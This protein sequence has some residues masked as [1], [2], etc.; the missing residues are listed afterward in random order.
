MVSDLPQFSRCRSRS[1]EDLSRPFVSSDRSMSA[2]RA[3]HPITTFPPLGERFLACDRLPLRSR[4]SL[5]SRKTRRVPLAARW[6]PPARGEIQSSGSSA[7]PAQ[8]R[9]TFRPLPD[10]ASGRRR[11]ILRPFHGRARG[12][13]LLTRSPS[14]FSPFPVSDGDPAVEVREV[15]CRSVCGSNRSARSA[16]RPC[17]EICVQHRSLLSLCP[18]SRRAT[19]RLWF[20]SSVRG[21]GGRTTSSSRS[22][23]PAGRGPRRET[24]HRLLCRCDGGDLMGLGP[25]AEVAGEVECLRDAATWATRAFAARD[26][27]P[28]T[29]PKA[30]ARVTTEVGPANAE[31]SSGRT[32]TPLPPRGSSG[33]IT[34]ERGAACPS[35][36]CRKTRHSR[37]SFL[38]CAVFFGRRPFR[39]ASRSSDQERERGSYDR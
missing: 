19:G 26:A 8:F 5:S 20:P 18:S 33:Q 15:R 13:L 30:R 23:A 16:L 37:A 29:A 28:S 17:L 7:E 3:I 10:G 27:A 14:C 9:S 34:G 1:P 31:T 6:S 12:A 22:T 4:P 35:G 24:D 11:Q 38:F 25:F 39:A 36:R 2:R 32:R 21:E